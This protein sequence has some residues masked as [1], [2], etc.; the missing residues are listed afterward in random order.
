M[1]QLATKSPK[2]FAYLVFVFSSFV[3]GSQDGYK[4]WVEL[5]R[6]KNFINLIRMLTRAGGEHAMY[7]AAL[8]VLIP[9]CALVLLHKMGYIGSKT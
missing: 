8:P 4:K 2:T 6:D 3:F 1:N 9:F 5:T 7:A